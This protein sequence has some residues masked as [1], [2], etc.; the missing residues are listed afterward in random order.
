MD[1]TKKNPPLMNQTRATQGGTIYVGKGDRRTVK[2]EVR[3]VRGWNPL[4]HGVSDMQRVDDISAD[5]I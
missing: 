5:K 3:L 4:G 2:G 1:Y